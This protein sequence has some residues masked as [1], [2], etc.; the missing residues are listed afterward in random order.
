MPRWIE[1]RLGL[2]GME[3]EAVKAKARKLSVDGLDI[4]LVRKRVR[5]INLS[6]RS[7][8]A[9][10]RVT[11]PR[12]VSIAEIEAFVV[13]KL[14]WIRRKRAEILAQ[15]SAA[16]REFLDGELHYLW[17]K[18]LSL[19]VEERLTGNRIE[20]EGETLRLAVRPG[21]DRAHR[22][23]LLE[24]WQRG[25]V[26]GALPPLLETWESRMGLKAGGISVRTMKSR[27]GTCDTVKRDIR[28][29][30]QLAAKPPECLEYVLVHELAHFMD[31]SHGPA[32]K[33][34]MDHWLPDW[35]ER[36]ALLNRLATH[37]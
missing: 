27:W 10:L 17:G 19:L 24:A 23:A 1:G 18:P 14:A 28:I 34:I 13:S 32:F 9:E 37:E 15:P 30:A 33:S 8:G 31:S 36:R 16:E 26:R 6:V 25:L 7:P 2:P 4:E 22:K 35:R 12:H 21:S 20:V 11:V 3:T 29:N 5:N